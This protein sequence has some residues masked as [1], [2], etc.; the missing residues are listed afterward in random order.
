MHRNFVHMP[1]SLVDASTSEKNFVCRLANIECF[2]SA[3]RQRGT[4]TRIEKY[5][6]YILDCILASSVL[7]R[8]FSR[9][10]INHFCLC[11]I[12]VLLVTFRKRRKESRVYHQKWYVLI[13]ISSFLW[14]VIH[15]FH[16]K[17]FFY[18]VLKP[19]LLFHHS[20]TK[21]TIYIFIYLILPT[22]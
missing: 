22:F 6:S 12:H 19:S 10:F 18:Q 15:F 2:L 17:I 5:L 1:L 8:S 9:H 16:M 7:R 20:S 11:T 13:P 4:L 14:L 3:G 21:T